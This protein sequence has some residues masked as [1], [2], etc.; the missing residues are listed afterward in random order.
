MDK[1]R[2]KEA[3]ETVISHE[4]IRSGIGTLGEKS[5]HA[6]LKRYYEP[7]ESCHEVP[8]GS[9]VADIV[10]ENGIIEIQTRQF[11]KLLKKL[12]QFLEFSRVTVVYPVSAKKSIIWIDPET[13]EIAER[14]T[15]PKKGRIYDILPEL[16]RIKYTLDN[17]RLS[18]RICLLEVEELR[19]LDGWSGDRKK[20]ATKGDRIPTALL[21]EI[22]LDCPYDHR[23][24]LPEGLKKDFTSADYAKAAR[25]PVKNARIGLNLLTYLGLVTRTGEGPRK[26]IIYNTNI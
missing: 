6:V 22:E 14:R 13:G 11:N 26:T 19:L 1:E 4:R 23:I 18:V 7:D 25:I 5:T 2:F 3:C 21:D 15:S 17:P 10:G 24:F 9:F 16:Y 8:V 12:E 20:G